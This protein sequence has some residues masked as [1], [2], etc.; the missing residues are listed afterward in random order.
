MANSTKITS[1]LVPPD[2]SWKNLKD[3]I[4]PGGEMKF[5]LGRQKIPNGELLEISFSIKSFQK[6][7]DPTYLHKRLD[8]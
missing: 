3:L 6:L 7:P 4:N 1:G 5:V 2:P 8:P